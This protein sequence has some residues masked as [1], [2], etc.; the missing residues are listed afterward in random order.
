[1]IRISHDKNPTVA[2]KK[3]RRQLQRASR[4]IRDYQPFRLGANAVYRVSDINRLIIE[5]AMQNLSPEAVSLLSGGIS[6]DDAL[7]HLKDKAT[8]ERIE[9]MLSEQLDKRFLKLLRRKHPDFHKRIAIDF[10]PEYFYGDKECEYVT[11][12]K[13]KDSTYYCFKFMTVSL[14]LPE[15]KFLLFAYPAYRGTD[16]I[17]LLN[18]AFES[19]K[20][21][22]IEP[23]L[24]LMDREF[25]SV[26]V[27]VLCRELGVHYL[28]PAKHDKKFERYVK[29]MDK[30]PGMV[31]DYEITNE[32]NES[33]CTN[34]VV[35]ESLDTEETK[36]FGFITNLPDSLYK[37]DVYVLAEIYRK[38][39]RIENAHRVHDEFR[40]RTCCKEGNVRYFFFVVAVLLYNLWVWINLVLRDC[41]FGTGSLHI[42]VYQMKV[43]LFDFFREPELLFPVGTAM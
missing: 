28:I 32:Q 43:Q 11:G 18:R 2:N 12:Y 36:V 23:E 29:G 24:V 6:A 33:V 19:L 13:P 35:M 9:Q 38:R 22:G 10:T 27:L 16:R 31:R 5:A 37:D 41:S 4:G 3:L 1:M 30:L 7:L 40:V 39:W 34:L 8:I 42:T 14:L 25:Y 20:S 21:L 26:D 17:W 15:G